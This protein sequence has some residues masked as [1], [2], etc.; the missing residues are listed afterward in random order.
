MPSN[1]ITSPPY[2]G[3]TA[4]NRASSQPESMGALSDLAHGGPQMGL[5]V[6]HGLLDSMR[7]SL[8]I[9]GQ[10]VGVFGEETTRLGILSSAIDTWERIQALRSDLALRD[11]VRSAQIE[12]LKGELRN[13]IEQRARSALE[14]VIKDA[15]ANSSGLREKVFQ[16]L[17][18]Q[19][20]TAL[21]IQLQESKFRLQ[22][23]QMELYNSEARRQNATVRG[24]S[25]P[26]RPLLRPLA[27]PLLSASNGNGMVVPVTPAQPA[28]PPV[29][30]ATPHQRVS[31]IS[32]ASSSESNSSTSSWEFEPPTPSDRFPRDLKEFASFDG[33]AM[34]SL[35][36]EY[37]LENGEGREQGMNVFLTHINVPA[38]VVPISANP[39]RPGRLPIVF[40]STH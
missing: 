5:E 26:L 18:A 39:G 17:T 20:P 22:R 29:T 28:P 37:G 31:S 38:Q 27:M 36:L 21:L 16:Q 32:S 23:I 3:Q 1:G 12:D 8:S 2:G 11:S 33:E 6:I 10:E 30:P 25:E 40:T 24:Q 15:V 34:H 4:H 14:C 13:V 9:I 35:L 7:P 19:V